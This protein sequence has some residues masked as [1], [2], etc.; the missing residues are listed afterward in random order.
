MEKE[1]GRKANRYVVTIQTRSFRK[2]YPETTHKLYYIKLNKP[3]L[4]HHIAFFLTRRYIFLYYFI[5]Y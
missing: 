3:P 2:F 5:L 1:R 4:K